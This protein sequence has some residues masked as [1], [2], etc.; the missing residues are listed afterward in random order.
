MVRIIPGIRN[1]INIKI[2]VV[3]I[4]TEIRYNIKIKVVVVRII[5]WIRDNKEIKFVVFRIIPGIR[6][7]KEIKLQKLLLITLIHLPFL[8]FTILQ[9]DLIVLVSIAFQSHVYKYFEL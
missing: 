8:Y 7:N 6:D 5:T 9:L 3:R 2:V 4:I 1:N